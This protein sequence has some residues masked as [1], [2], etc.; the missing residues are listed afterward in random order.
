VPHLPQGAPTSPGLANLAAVVLDRRLVSYAAVLGVKYTRYAD[1]LTFSGSADLSTRRLV[2][3]VTTIAQ[4]EGFALNTAKTRV[5]PAATRQL[6]TGVVVNSRP[7]VPREQREQLRAV[8]HEAAVH[9]VEVANRARHPD[10]RAHLNGRVG[11]VEAVNPLQGSRLRRQFDT[12]A[13]P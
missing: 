9:G 12:I 2:R 13:W 11:W 7:G 4:D 5:R 6:V 1:D 10:F 3:A 8:L